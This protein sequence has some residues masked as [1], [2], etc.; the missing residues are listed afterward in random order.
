MTEILAARDIGAVFR[1]LK[2][3]GFSRAAIAAAT[4]L[5]ETRVREIIQ[6]RQRIRDY[7][8]F[9]RVASGL[10]I[11]RGLLGLSYATTPATASAGDDELAGLSDAELAAHWGDLLSVVASSADHCGGRPVWT[12]TTRQ[13]SLIEARCRSRR[14]NAPL[15]AVNARWSEFASWVADNIGEHDQARVLAGRALRQATEA[16]DQHA[17]AYILMRHAQQSAEHGHGDRAVA[18][19]TRAM[20][21]VNDSPRT[22]ALCLVRQAHGH[23]LMRDPRASR[24]A[25]RRAARL[26]D[27]SADY[28]DPLDAHCTHLYIEGYE[29]LCRLLLGDNHGAVQVLETV[30]AEWSPG[31][32]RQDEVLW[33]AWLTD[34]YTQVGRKPDAGEE[35]QRALALARATGSERARKVLDKVA[36]VLTEDDRVAEVTQFLAAHR[37]MMTVWKS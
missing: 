13:L 8:V 32:S 4:G 11:D 5:S 2:T 12:L 1:F 35:G 23:A 17:A 7:E 24:S 16:G 37:D 31:S 18:Q 25:V 22:T 29:G 14:S 9:E 36:G 26:V 19:A 30:L 27:N 21:M 10:A 20:A 33:R 34:A 28:G 15:L 6:G 3:R